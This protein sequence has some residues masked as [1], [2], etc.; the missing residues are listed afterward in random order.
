MSIEEIVKNQRDYY[1]TGAT[2]PLEFRLTALRKLQK[3]VRDHEKQ[4]CDAL[5]KDLNKQPFESYMAEDRK[6]VV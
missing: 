3:A 2:R 4:I 1:M 6:S 5:L